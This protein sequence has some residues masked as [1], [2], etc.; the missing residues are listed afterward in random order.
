[1]VRSPT[2]R[3]PRP[4]PFD[5][6]A[7]LHVKPRFTGSV[8]KPCR[9]TL[10]SSGLVLLQVVS[11]PLPS[12][13]PKADAHDVSRRAR[14]PR[15]RGPSL[16]SSPP[17]Y[18]QSG[19]WLSHPE[20]RDCR[21]ARAFE[22]SQNLLLSHDGCPSSKTFSTS[23]PKSLDTSG[24]KTVPTPAQ[25]ALGTSNPQID[26]PCLG[27]KSLGTGRS[28]DLSML[29]LRSVGTSGSEEP[30]APRLQKASALRALKGPS[31]PRT[32]EPSTPGV[33]NPLHRSPR[34]ILCFGPPERDLPLIPPRSHWYEESIIDPR[35]LQLGEPQRI[36]VPKNYR[37]LD[38][39]R[40]IQLH[41][42]ASSSVPKDLG[43]RLS[44]K[45]S[46]PS[47]SPYS[48]CP[49]KPSA[50]RLRRVSTLRAPMDR[51]NRSS[52]QGSTSPKTVGTSSF[53]LRH[54]AP[55][56]VGLSDL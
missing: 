48:L 8:V 14:R 7:S 15:K 52:E 46:G 19:V 17:A 36:R 45:P 35:H 32:H 13:Y 33:H 4:K 25:R 10:P 3:C 56:T 28:E 47:P 24:P 49:S 31:A 22:P 26:L 39:S 37:H 18:S 43:R 21:P 6:E 44:I 20:R 54:A 29:W 30:S 50:L 53:D 23:A 1:M 11:R 16:S 40:T 2:N 41:E 5:F 38:P 27:F 51:G 42:S 55:R 12:D 9:R 34:D